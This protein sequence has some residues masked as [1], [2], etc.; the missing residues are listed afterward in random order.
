[1]IYLMGIIPSMTF[2]YNL[3]MLKG[4]ELLI[5]SF[6]HSPLL[7]LVDDRAF[8]YFQPLFRLHECF[9]YYFK[10]LHYSRVPTYPHFILDI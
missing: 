4:A 9:V 2:A 5:I 8:L 10:P 7:L 1:M 6:V 3:L